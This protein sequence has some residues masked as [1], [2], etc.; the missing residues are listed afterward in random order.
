M[1]TAIS[2][3]DEAWNPVVGC[4]PVSPGC[5]NCYAARVAVRLGRMPDLPQYRGTARDDLTGQPRWTGAVRTVPAA[6]GIPLRWIRPR[7]VFVGSMTD[8]FHPR[9]PV[10]WLNRVWDVMHH[11]DHLYLIL[12]KR[13]GRMLDF[14]AARE[15]GTPPANI[16]VGTSIETARQVHRLGHLLRCRKLVGGTFLSLE[17][18]LGSLDN[19]LHD[20]ACRELPGRKGDVAGFVDWVIAGGESGAG[21]RP[22]AAEWAREVR[23]LCR[24]LHIP[25]HFKQWGRSGLGRHLD[26]R[27]HDW[28]PTPEEC[29]V[30]RV[31]GPCSCCGCHV[32]ALRHGRCRECL[33]KLRSTLALEVDAR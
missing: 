31:A 12:T 27:T 15:R 13:P 1:A 6:L 26:G 29:L 2:W 25:F 5:A 3:A 30:E 7:T 32:D 21:A 4:E 19:E 16:W 33:R 18:L 8:M 23:L 24:S 11:T 10:T 9:V 20:A 28:Y 22:M 17:P 14:L